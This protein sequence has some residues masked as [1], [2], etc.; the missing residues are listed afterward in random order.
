MITVA[1]A[2]HSFLKTVNGYL[3]TTKSRGEGYKIRVVKP[4]KWSEKFVFSLFF[5]L[6]NKTCTV[7]SLFKM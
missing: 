4:D 3:K 6:L 5:I 1:P 7:S 2:L